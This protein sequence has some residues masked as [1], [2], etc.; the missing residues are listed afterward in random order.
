MRSYQYVSRHRGP[1]HLDDGAEQPAFPGD[2][3]GRSDDLGDTRGVDAVPPCAVL[4]G[5]L[6]DSYIE[7][8]RFEHL[9]VHRG[10]ALESLI[11]SETVLGHPYD[12]VN[13]DAAPV[14]G[15]QSATG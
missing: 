11:Q 9:D 13:H 5:Q 15:G 6:A 8:E 4:A 12:V 1:R 7:T 14:V 2:P 3:L 10:V